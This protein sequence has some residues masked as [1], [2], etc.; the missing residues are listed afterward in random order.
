MIPGT[1]VS[2]HSI[3]LRYGSVHFLK[4]T[5]CALYVFKGAKLIQTLTLIHSST[6]PNHKYS[7]AAV[8]LNCQS[9]YIRKPPGFLV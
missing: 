7:V 3:P 4:K 9:K 8:S 1:Q 6:Q 2:T 5:K